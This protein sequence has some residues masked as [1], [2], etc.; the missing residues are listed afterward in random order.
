MSTEAASGSP[1][2][3]RRPEGRRRRLPLAL[4]VIATLVGFL[5]IFAVW[6]NRQLLDTDN[7]TETSSE[8][9]EDDAIRAQISTFLVDALYA[10]V[11]VEG[12]IEQA[13]PPRAAPLAGPAAGGLKQFAEQATDELLQRP[14]PQALWESAN[15]RAH[16]RFV[17]VVE[18]GGDVVSTEGGDVTL[19]LDELLG[20]TQERVGVGGRAAERLPEDAAQLTILHSDQLGFAQDL[21]DAFRVLV[22]VL[23]LLALGLYGLAVYLARGWRREAL[24]AC[25]F[26]LVF[27]GGAALVARSL[28]GDAVVEGLV[29]TAS[30]E[31]AATA[32]WSISTSLLQE[33]AAATLAYGIVI[34]AAAWLAGPAGWAVAIRR[35]LAPY[36]REP[37][38]AYGALAAIVLV[39]LAWSP[40]PATRRLLPALLLIG[41]LAAGIEAL[42]RQTAREY[43]D[44]SVEES[45]R[46]MRAWLS[47]RGRGGKPPDE[48]AETDT[49]AQLERL[50]RLRDAGV[51]EPGEFRREKARLLAQAPAGAD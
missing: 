23:V 20:A 13:L 43:P 14:R 18:G 30:V 12:R 2:D 28:A 22:V 33:A 45:N 26:S 35:A 31:P 47:A 42:R 10:N 5:A 7:W 4:I 41:L 34:V 1:E 44:A 36:L 40:T 24:R 50:G 15:R 3:V 19:D 11:D 46:R 29:T 38:Y 9:L 49:L 21:V 27:A 17:D 37:A 32:A 51:L 16:M 8:L 25:G 39:L 6:A 48:A